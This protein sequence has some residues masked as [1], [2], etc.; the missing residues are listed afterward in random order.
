MT[1][2]ECFVAHIF[3]TTTHNY[4]PLKLCCPRREEDPWVVLA[5]KHTRPGKLQVYEDGKEITAEQNCDTGE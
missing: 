3:A 4:A 5:L 1:T 2:I